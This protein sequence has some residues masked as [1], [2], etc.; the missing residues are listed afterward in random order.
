MRAVSLALILLIFQ[1][2]SHSKKYLVEVGGASSNEQ[3]VRKAGHDPEREAARDNYGEAYEYEDED[4]PDDIEEYNPISDIG[5]T[6][7]NDLIRINSLMTLSL[8]ENRK[9]KKKKKKKPGYN[10]ERE[11]ARPAGCC[12]CDKCLGS[13]SNCKECYSDLYFERFPDRKVTK[14]AN[15]H[16]DDDDNYG[17]AY[18][19]EYEENFPDE[20]EEYNPSISDIGKT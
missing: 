12:V 14:E 8:I 15:H 2:F 4:F 16:V 1:N 11:K 18:E 3:R 5:I 17:E 7:K 10:A 13:P 9:R 19:Y 20:I 6:Y